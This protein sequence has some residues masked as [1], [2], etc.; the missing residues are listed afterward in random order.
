VDITRE[1][2]IERSVADVYAFIA[3][4]RNDP[5]WCPKVKSV[6]QVEGEGPGPGARYVV[7]H[8]PVPL[9]PARRMDHTCVA[10]EPP[11]RIQWREDDGTDLFQVTYELE[12]L[13]GGRTRLRQHSNARLGAARIMH[14]LYRAGVGR[15]LDVQLRALKKLLEAG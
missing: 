9:K 15:D 11:R 4:A 12:D 13:E 1:I 6:E 5:R 10:S 14:P 3:D 7:V 8:K 2:V